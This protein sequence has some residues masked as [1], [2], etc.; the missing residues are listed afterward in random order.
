MAGEEHS[1]ARTLEADGI[2]SFKPVVLKTV[3]FPAV[4]TILL[5]S[6]WGPY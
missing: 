3:I 6:V 2:R 5:H 1:I 4:V